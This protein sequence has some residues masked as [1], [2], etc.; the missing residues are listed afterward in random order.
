MIFGA[1][2]PINTAAGSEASDARTTARE[3]KTEVEQLRGDVERL[4]LLTEALWRLVK[5]RTECSD[6]DLIRRIHDIDLEDGKLDGRKA[7]TPPRP[8]PHCQRILSKHRALCLFC[9]KPVEFVPFE[10]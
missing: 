10:R 2:L 3:A 1:S 7:K 5:E 8:C 6:E 9:G 4:M